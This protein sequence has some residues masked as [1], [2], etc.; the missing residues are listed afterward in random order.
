LVRAAGSGQRRWRRNRDGILNTVFATTV[1]GKIT[2]CVGGIIFPGMRQ[3]TEISAPV[4]RSVVPIFRNLIQNRIENSPLGA[5][6]LPDTGF[7]QLIRSV[8][9]NRRFKITQPERRFRMTP[10]PDW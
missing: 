1:A 9:I 2:P 7:Q 3:D 5:R 4:R 8:K 10:R 6:K